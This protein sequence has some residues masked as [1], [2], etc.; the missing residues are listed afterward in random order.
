M[1][2]E[3]NS[4][5]MTPHEIHFYLNIPY[6][7]NQQGHACIYGRRRNSSANETDDAT[8]QLHEHYN[9][10]DLQFSEARP[11]ITRRDVIHGTE[12]SCY[13]VNEMEYGH[14]DR[15]T[16]NHVLSLRRNFHGSLLKSVEFS[17][18]RGHSSNNIENEYDLV[19]VSR[20]KELSPE[21][22]KTL[23]EKEA[24]RQGL[25]DDTINVYIDKSKLMK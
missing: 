20:D 25:I 16:G 21:N 5:I 22:E 9:Y 15:S 1:T 14:F 10:S 3:T 7:E 23:L 4:D 8:L 19:S 6:E 18:M 24:I 13:D 11:P 17:S 12:I 2:K